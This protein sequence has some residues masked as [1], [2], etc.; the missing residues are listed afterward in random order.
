[1]ILLWGAPGDAPLDAVA[2]ALLERGA[3]ARFLDQRYAARTR[4]ML[5]IAT[6]GA[7]SGSISDPLGDIDVEEI[8]ALYLRPIE[9]TKALQVEDPNDPV[10]TRGMATDATIVA[11]ADVTAAAVVNRPAAMSPNNSK[12]EQLRWIARLGFAVPDT[13]VTTDASAARSF[14]HSYENVIYKSVSGVRSIVSRLGDTD[15]EALENVANCP[16]QFQQ[17]IPGTDVRVH[18]IGEA[19]FA[20]EIRSAVDDYRYA[21]RANASVTMAAI[22]LPPDFAAS[23][24][25]MARAM[26]LHVAGIDFRRTPDGRWYCLEVN[27][28]PGF[29][30][31]EAATNQPIT[32]AVSD[33][34]VQLDRAVTA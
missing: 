20:C 8:G 11:W 18:V 21:A 31:Y 7:L 28:S 27:P 32:A 17:Y 25:N 26:D 16:T 6:D 1:M 3:R 10:L 24:V 13:L 4:V 22:D 23:C 15:D 9:T 12:P 5:S 29:T 19:T 33:L 14:R 30:Y 2:E 34:L